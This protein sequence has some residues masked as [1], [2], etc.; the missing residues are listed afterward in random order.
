MRGDRLL[1]W[2]TRATVEGAHGVQTLHHGRGG[3]TT[4][5]AQALIHIL[6]A[7]AVSMPT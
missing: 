5:T 1:T 7:V 4:V 3:A 2:R 6:A